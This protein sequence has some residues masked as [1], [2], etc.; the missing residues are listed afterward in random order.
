[1]ISK[2]SSILSLFIFFL[3]ISGHLCQV[4]DTEVTIND[5][6]SLNGNTLTIAAGGSLV[7]GPDVTLDLTGPCS[8][9]SP[10]LIE[11]VFKSINIIPDP[12]TNTQVLPTLQLT[13][14]KLKITGPTTVQDLKIMMDGNSQFISTS[15]TEFKYSLFAS[16]GSAF[17]GGTLSIPTG[18]FTMSSLTTKTLKLESKIDNKSQFITKLILL[19]INIQDLLPVTGGTL[20]APASQYYLSNGLKTLG[21][22]PSSTSLD[23]SGVYLRISGV[24][25]LGGATLFISAT[26]IEV[27]DSPVEV[28]NTRIIVNQPCVINAARSASMYPLGSLILDSQSTLTL[29]QANSLKLSLIVKSD[30]YME[31]GEVTSPYPSSDPIIYTTSGNNPITCGNYKGGSGT[32]F[33]SYQ[34][35]NKKPKLRGYAYCN[36]RVISVRSNLDSETSSD[37]IVDLCPEGEYRCFSAEG[38]CTPFET[39]CDTACGTTAPQ[40]QS[41]SGR[42]S[43]FE[44]KSALVNR[45]NS[46]HIEKARESLF[47]NIID[48]ICWDGTCSQ[49][50]PTCPPFPEC[51]VTTPKRCAGY[52]V[53]ANAQCDDNACVTRCAD[54]C[55]NYVRSCDQF[56]GCG[57]DE[58]ECPDRS[59]VSDVTQCPPTPPAG[60]GTDCWI[61]QSKKVLTSVTNAFVSSYSLIPSWY[62]DPLTLLGQPSVQAEIPSASFT[63]AIPTVPYSLVKIRNIPDSVVRGL[64][65][66]TVAGF[67]YYT[68]VHSSVFSITLDNQASTTFTDK[69]KLLFPKPSYITATNIDDYCLGY[70]K[71]VGSTQTWECTPDPLTISVDGLI[72]GKTDHFTNFGVLTKYRPTSTSTSATS[73]TTNFQ[74]FTTTSQQTTYYGDEIDNPPKQSSNTNRIVIIAASIA[75]GVIA[76]VIVAAIYVN[77]KQKHV[78]L[79]RWSVRRSDPNLERHLRALRESN[80]SIGSNSSSE[81]NL[82]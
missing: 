23:L 53:A 77:F 8:I 28:Q 29:S 21:I 20:T 49:V 60:C 2:S 51:G 14:I 82:V 25:N 56:N 6:V 1:M 63:P 26:I 50:Y 19:A 48:G 65:L 9:S 37:E 35:S 76:V 11:L 72:V 75:G 38:A 34:L 66:P 46:T 30:Y 47:S 43:R 4:I 78:S 41:Q 52:C 74:S 31:V 40:L 7:L 57:L 45:Q 42:L 39:V 18:S 73:S 15:T 81:N 79:R 24:L 32:G 5:K 58:I 70:I 22:Y 68:D 16:E 62:Y 80:Q 17:V 36:S 61:P 55:Y 10:V 67:S 54:G 64:S 59:C 3:F 33:V 69:V 13:N 27:R 71:T 44:V 12:N